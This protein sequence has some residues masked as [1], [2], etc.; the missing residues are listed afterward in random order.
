MGIPRIAGEA[1]GLDRRLKANTSKKRVYSLFRQ[2]L[3][4]Y[5]LIRNMPEER[6]RILMDALG[7]EVREHAVYRHAFGLI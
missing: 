3:I 6:L 4:W 2:G 5:R 1:S 7:R